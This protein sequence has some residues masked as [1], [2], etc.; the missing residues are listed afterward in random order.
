MIPYDVINAWGVTHPWITREQIEQDLLLSRAICE[1]YSNSFLSGE[2]I[3]RGGTA[4]HK[5]V[6]ST[7]YRYSEDLDFVRINAGGIG[8]II[9]VLTELGK[10]SGSQ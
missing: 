10:L 2:L 6:L 8:Y 7:P 4:L 1:I 5:L 3:F 9:K